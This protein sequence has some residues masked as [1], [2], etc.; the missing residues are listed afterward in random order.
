MPKGTGLSG[1]TQKYLDEIV[2]MLNTRPRKAW[3]FRCPAEIFTQLG[4]QSL[5]ISTFINNLRIL[6][7]VFETA[8][9]IFT[10]PEPKKSFRPLAA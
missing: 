9:Y 7:L 6:H 8:L 1:Y 2:W 3:H 10:Q 5:R 4:L